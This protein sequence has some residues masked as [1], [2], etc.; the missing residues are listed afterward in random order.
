MEPRIV[1][2]SG[3]RVGETLPLP[4]GEFV[5]GSDSDCRL[6]IDD[7]SV[8]GRHCV[9]TLRGGGAAVQDCETKSGTLLNGNAITARRVLNSGDRIGV[10]ESELVY[11]T[12][13]ET[14]IGEPPAFF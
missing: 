7:D 9:V 2:V 14:E 5:I 10:G 8:F 11:L 12:G 1:V 13:T 4:S 6:S 3:T